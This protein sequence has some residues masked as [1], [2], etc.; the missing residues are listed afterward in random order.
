[1]NIKRY[2]LLYIGLLNIYIFAQDQDLIKQIR[3]TDHRIDIVVN[4]EFKKAYL[5][6]DFFAEYN[7]DINLKGLDESLLIMPFIMQVI[8]LVWISGK[9]YYID[10]MDYLLYKSLKVVKE[11]FEHLYPNTQWCGELIPKKLVNNADMFVMHKKNN[12]S[13]ALMFSGGLDSTCMS[14]RRLEKKQLLVT[15][16][17][18]SDMPLDDDQQWNAVYKRI[19]DFAQLYGHEVSVVRSNYRNFL[20]RGYLHKLSPDI[21]C[22]RLDAVEG[23]GWIGLAVPILLSKGYNTLLIASSLT[24]DCPYQHAPMP[25]ID[26]NV[27]CAGLTFQHADFDL[28]RVQKAEFITALCNAYSIQKPFIR[29]CQKDK[30]GNNCGKCEKCIRTASCFIAVGAYPNEYGFDVTSKRLQKYLFL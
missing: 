30:V 5:R 12:E 2:V 8:S 25:L 19:E 26:D 20:R 1:M 22:W 21:T 13:I 16:R 29:A 7:N 4:S 17:G 27:F 10:S 18:H 15:A 11:V 9:Y 23:L 3:V 24:W 28:Q 14:L 6:D